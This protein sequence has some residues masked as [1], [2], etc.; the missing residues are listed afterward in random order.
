MAKG[1][2]CGDL[3]GYLGGDAKIKDFP[4][5]TSVG[6]SVGGNRRRRAGRQGC[7]DGAQRMA[8][9]GL[10]GGPNTVL[11]QR[12]RAALRPGSPRS[13]R[14]PYG[15]R[16]GSPSSTALPGSRRDAE[17][18]RDLSGSAGCKGLSRFLILTAVRGGEARLARWDETDLDS[19]E[20][21]IP[22]SR[23]KGGL[24]HRVPLN[25]FALD[26]AEQSRT[27][28]E[29]SGFVFLSPAQQGS[30]LSDMILTRVLRDKGLADQTTVHGIKSR[31]R[32]G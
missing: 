3:L 24:E 25:A 21:R 5:G 29:G 28:D 19:R 16:Q 2:N 8:C 32:V 9:G 12:R 15:S 13:S 22:S 14:P 31:L 10:A 11:G 4:D 27:L 23:M 1:L 18:R 30:P 6:G 7:L 20:W 17:H 26:V